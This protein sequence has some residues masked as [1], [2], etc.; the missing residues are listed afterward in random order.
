MRDVIRTC[1]GALDDIQIREHSIFIM[2]GREG[3]A[4]NLI[5]PIG[6]KGREY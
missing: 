2:H 5:F 4:I 3:F 1:C 6:I